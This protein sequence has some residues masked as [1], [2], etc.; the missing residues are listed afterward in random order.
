MSTTT[1]HPISDETYIEYGLGFGSQTARWYWGEVVRQSRSQVQRI[2]QQ[3][4][5]NGAWT[6][7]LYRQEFEEV[8]SDEDLIEAVRS[9][10]FSDPDGEDAEA[11]RTLRLRL[12]LRALDAR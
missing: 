3:I 12:A 4:D 2:A 7:E 10:F 11:W 8:Q 1:Q 5:P 9:A 6:D